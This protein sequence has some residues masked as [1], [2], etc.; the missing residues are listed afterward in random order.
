MAKLPKPVLLSALG[1]FELLNAFQLDLFRKEILESDLRA[2][3]ASF[4]ADL[5]SKIFTVTPMSETMFTEARRL[6]A[7]WSA[8]LG[9]RSLDILQVA[10]AMVLKADIFVTFDER[11]KKLA[12]ASGLV[13]R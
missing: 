7:R 5:E 11:Q 8:K 9:A 1:E 10:A 12:K 6:S 2:A 3:V 4:R 13:C